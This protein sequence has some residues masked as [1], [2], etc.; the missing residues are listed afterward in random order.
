MITIEN[1]SE[2]QKYTDC[3]YLNTTTQN[4][5]ANIK[6]QKG[7]IAP[8]SNILSFNT[9]TKYVIELHLSF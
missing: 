7:Y 5:N 3:S 6:Y 2:V 1:K 8:Q 9:Q 4:C